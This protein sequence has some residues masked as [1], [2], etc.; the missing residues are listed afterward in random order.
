MKPILIKLKD[1]KN[2]PCKKYYNYIIDNYGKDKLFN[3]L[4]I[5]EK[6]NDGYYGDVSWLIANC[7]KYQTKKMIDY[8][9]LFNPKY[10]NISW[11]ISECKICQTQKMLN[12]YKSLNPDYK[13]V[14]R[15]IKYCE[16]CQ[17][18]EMYKY[19]KSLIFFRVI[20]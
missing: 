16:Y 5:I 7:K 12:Y 15:L 3:P 18:D 1:L 17:T 8:Y 4:K 9:K 19:L 6:L 10:W 14:L 11:L 13:D 20:K 2:K